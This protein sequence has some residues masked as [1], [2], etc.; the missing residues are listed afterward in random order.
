MV[1]SVVF[2]VRRTTS[3]PVRPSL[4]GVHTWMHGVEHCCREQCHGWCA[5]VAAPS[6]HSPLKED[7]Q[8]KNEEGEWSP[9]CSHSSMVLQM[10]RAGDAIHGQ[11]IERGDGKLKHL[12]VNGCARA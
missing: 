7:G 2:S 8:S 6:R 11:R 3:W 9:K 1:F 4:L 12:S 5:H 10:H